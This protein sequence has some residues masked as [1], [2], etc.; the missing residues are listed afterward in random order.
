MF[1]ARGLRTIGT[2]ADCGQTRTKGIHEHR[3]TTSAWDGPGSGR[4]ERHATSG[5]LRRIRDYR[6][7]GEGDDVPLALSPGA[8]WS[9]V[10]PDRRGGR[11]RLDPPGAAPARPGRDRGNGRAD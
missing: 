9:P 8:A 11:E 10:L 2:A 6:G 3:G 7:P 1:G 4:G 5:R